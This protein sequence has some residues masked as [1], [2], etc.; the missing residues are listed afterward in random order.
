MTAA[1]FIALLERKLI[2]AG[3][4]K[5]VPDQ[6]TLEA[7]YRQAYRIALAQNAVDSALAAIGASDVPVPP[8]SLRKHINKL[9]RGETLAWDEAIWQ[10]VRKLAK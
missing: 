2:A 8:A 6:A 1:Q 3:A 7:A 9:I 10:T 5:L 4:I